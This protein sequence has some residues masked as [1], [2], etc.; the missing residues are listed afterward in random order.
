MLTYRWSAQQTAAMR[1]A[2]VGF[3][4]EVLVRMR[5]Q[6]NVAS[7][8]ESIILKFAADRK[9]LG[10]SPKHP[11]HILRHRRLAELFQTKTDLDNDRISTVKLHLIAVLRTYWQSSIRE[12]KFDMQWKLS[13]LSDRSRK[14]IA[15]E[16]LHKKDNSLQ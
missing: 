16:Q 11:R 15:F 6:Q 4:E 8:H 1:K 2:C 9:I 12:H 14:L 10:F 3:A 7:F 5:G 13:S